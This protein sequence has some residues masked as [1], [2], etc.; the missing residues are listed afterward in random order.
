MDDVR[1]I[2]QQIKADRRSLDR[3]IHELEHRA[4]AALDWRQQYRDHAGTA[5][6]VALGSGVLLGALSRDRGRE[7]STDIG[8]PRRSWLTA[9]DPSGRAGG[10]LSELVSDVL[11]AF[12]G[13]A[14]TA[15]VDS[16]A[17]AVP[18]FRDQFDVGKRRPI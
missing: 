15:V 11:D 1:T 17:K 5:L 14:G 18:G 9:I 10:H 8:V 6:A 13:L 3:K 7:Y 12:V 4:H 16:I 2:E